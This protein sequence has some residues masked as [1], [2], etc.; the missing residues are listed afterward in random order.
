MDAAE[1]RHGLAFED[2]FAPGPASDAEPPV[3]DLADPGY[4]T[5]L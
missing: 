3:N 1:I 4:K 2:C 5:P